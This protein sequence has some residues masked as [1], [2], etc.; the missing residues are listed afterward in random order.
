[1]L[2]VLNIIPFFSISSF[3]GEIGLSGSLPWPVIVVSMPKAHTNGIKNRRVEPLSPQ[4]RFAFLLNG[5]GVTII[6]SSLTEISVPI[7]LRQSTV[8][9]I[10]FDITLHLIFVVLSESDAQMRILCASDFDE[11]ALILPPKTDGAQE[12]VPPQ[13]A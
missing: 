10:S 6:V 3:N 5:C 2:L 4:S 7:D 13:C 11:I 9:A 1:M 12:R 8:A